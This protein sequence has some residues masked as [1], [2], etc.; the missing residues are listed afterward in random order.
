MD[1]C[2]K[3][4][5]EFRNEVS[6]ILTRHET[7]FDNLNNNFNQVTVT[8][9]TVLTEIQALRLNKN[10]KSSDREDNPFAT[11]KTSPHMASHG[12]HVTQPAT[13]NLHNLIDRNNT[14]LKL[15]FTTFG[16][17]DS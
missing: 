15:S 12:C 1:T 2:S 4:N 6:E 16:G 13:P 17:A 7:S 9:Q 14:Q 5:A 3:S 10:N 11:A 8:M